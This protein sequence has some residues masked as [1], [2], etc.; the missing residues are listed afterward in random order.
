[1]VS[2][3][4]VDLAEDN[5]SSELTGVVLDVGNRVAIRLDGCVETSEIPAGTPTTTRFWCDMKG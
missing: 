5:F 4:Q 1:V 3:D 2:L